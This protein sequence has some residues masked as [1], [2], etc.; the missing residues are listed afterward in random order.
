MI[1]PRDVLDF[2][3]G[4]PGSAEYGRARALWFAKSAATDAD[5]RARFGAA[6]EA[7]LQ[8]AFEE[9]RK[10]SR[11][12]LAL[13]LLLD[14]FTRNIFRGTA[15]AFAG[16]V[17]ALALARELVARGDDLSFSLL[18]RQF[19]YLPFE[20][21]EDRQAQ[22]ESLRLFG[23]L[24]ADGLPE[25]FEWAK[26]HYDAIARFGRFPHRNVILGRESTPQEI[27]FLK[28]PGSRF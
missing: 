10:T 8:G 16:D 14:Q 26:R 2:W 22:E 28:L 21:A 9:W 27:E 13:I 1:V 18:E 25:P 20:H 24:A 11:E 4:T 17:R 23:R 6:V 5:I 15:R 3:F 12:A 19:A 7:A